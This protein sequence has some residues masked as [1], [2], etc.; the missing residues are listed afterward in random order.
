MQ[1]RKVHRFRRSAGEGLQDDLSG[2]SKLR[3][4]LL[5]DGRFHLQESRGLRYQQR[6]RQ[7]DM[8][9][10]GA[11]LE[12]MEKPGLGALQGVAWDPHPQGDT[13][14]GLEADAEDL[15]GETVGILLDH[16]EG[17]VL[18][19][20]VDARREDRRDA[21]ALQEDHQLA[22]LPLLHPGFP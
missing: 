5:H 19:G 1:R 17:L 8:A 6:P 3:Q 13:V 4:G 2:G 10:G 16:P 11:F 15:Q 14:G 22:N 9:D 20:V 21:Q 7:I 18:V 12:G